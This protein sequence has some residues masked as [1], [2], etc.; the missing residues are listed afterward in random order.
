MQLND[1]ALPQPDDS[2]RVVCSM[3][4]SE[5]DIYRWQFEEDLAYE[6]SPD[7]TCPACERMAHPD[8]AELFWNGEWTI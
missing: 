1:A 6:D 5:F 3:C 2:V 4:S 7:W 8:S